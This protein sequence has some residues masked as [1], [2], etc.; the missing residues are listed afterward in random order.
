M[1]RLLTILYL[2]KLSRSIRNKS[3]ILG[4]HVLLQ[5]FIIFF[6]TLTISAFLFY[7][8]EHSAPN[9]EIKTMGDALWWTIQTASTST[10]G[11][12]PITP[13]GRIVG[14]M[15]MLGI[16]TTFISTLAA[17]LMRS[18]TKGTST[19]NDPKMILKIRLA[20]VRSQK[21]LI[22]SW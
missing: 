7:S 2:I 16:T 8:A 12:N 5:I 14:S 21:N 22:R 13:A 18:R 17:G 1:L 15:V 11:P 20:K 6:L 10:F 9:S 3:R 19:E 4:G